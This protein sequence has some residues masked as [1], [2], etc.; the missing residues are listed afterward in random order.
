MESL[1]SA[2][3][4][5]F[6][7]NQGFSAPP[8]V[9]SAVQPCRQSPPFAQPWWRPACSG[10]ACFRWRV[11]RRISRFR[12]TRERAGRRCPIEIF[13]SFLVPQTVAGRLM[14]LDVVTRR[15]RRPANST[16]CAALEL[17]A[18]VAM[19]PA[20]VHALHSACA[21]RL[22]PEHPLQE[23][24]EQGAHLLIARL[25]LFLS[26]SAS[27]KWSRGTATHLRGRDSRQPP[28]HLQL[29]IHQAWGS[30]FQKMSN[31]TSSRSSSV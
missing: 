8:F 14:E 2:W 11:H 28:P 13:A 27:S 16:T 29:H 22:C 19:L 12:R 26:G 31:A 23:R 24:L 21:F 3:T 5:T 7:Y 6:P 15:T 10:S 1:R 18:L 9:G 30:P 17:D 25:A 4:V 20:R